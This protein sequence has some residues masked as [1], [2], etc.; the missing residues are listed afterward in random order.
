MFSSPR[1]I[2]LYDGEVYVCDKKNHRIQVFDRDLNLVRAFGS[3]GSNGG[4]FNY[5]IN[6]DFDYFGIA[7]IADLRNARIKVVD[8][9]GQFIRQIHHRNGTGKP[10]GVRVI[11]QLVYVT[12]MSEKD[13]TVYQT[14]GE[15]VTSFRSVSQIKWLNSIYGITPDKSGSI[16]L[17]DFSNDRIIILDNQFYKNLT[18]SFLSQFCTVCFFVFWGVFLR[19]K[20]TMVAT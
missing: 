2:T 5:P 6:I 20:T 4:Q 7:Y 9:D 3:Y 12:D 16:Y 18:S 10:V 17:C 14:T 15:Y 8:A 11:G 1:G 13:V 19:N